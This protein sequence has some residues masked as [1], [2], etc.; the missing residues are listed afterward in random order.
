[1]NGEEKSGETGRGM[2]NYR[3]SL[4]DEIEVLKNDLNDELKRRLE[5]PITTLLEVRQITLIASY[6]SFFLSITFSVSF[7][8][9]S[10]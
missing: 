2:E 5:L 8:L 9:F 3:N 10:I 7:F 4:K 1:M 6:I